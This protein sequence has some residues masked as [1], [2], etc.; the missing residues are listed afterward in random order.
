MS[1]LLLDWEEDLFLFFSF[2]LSLF[3]SEEEDE[4]LLDDLRL[5]DFFLCFLDSFFD[6][7]DLL[8]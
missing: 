7:L 4:F 6:V 1:R 3:S 2:F 8:R 5:D